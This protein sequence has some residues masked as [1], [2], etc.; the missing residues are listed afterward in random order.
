[1]ENLNVMVTLFII[2]ILGYALNKLGYLNENFD[3]KLSAIVVDVTCPLLILSSVMGNTLPDRRL[4][5]PLLA[6]GFFTYIILTI[7]AFT[8]PRFITKDKDNQGITGF[9]MMFANVGFIGYPIVAS[10]F[11]N[12][13]VFYAALLNMAN[14]FFIFTTGVTLVNG[15]SD[16]ENEKRGTISMLLHSFNPKLLLSPAMLAAFASAIIVAFQ[17]KIPEIIASPV[18]MV[19]NITI[20]A[21]LMII[22]SSMAE[23]PIS[24]MLGN[25]IV[26]ITTAFRLAIIPIGLYFLFAAI[27]IQPIVN[28]INTVVIAMPV[29]SFGTMFCLKYNKDA[30]LM[31]QMTF[32]STI[33]SIISI[34]LITQLFKG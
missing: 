23:L 13:A 26:Y 32:A 20:P 33:G 22:G 5:L 34:P 16:S 31:V 1:M 17:W 12:N 4:I 10:I 30:S 11:G 6:T 21:S 8:I 25:R 19:G 3:K 27:G 7:V 29:A 14:T 15:I 28:D 24:R 2:V 9:A 18:S